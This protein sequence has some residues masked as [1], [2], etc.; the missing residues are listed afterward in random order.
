M[1]AVWNF[2]KAIS[3]FLSSNSQK[4]EKKEKKFF[5]KSDEK[6]FGPYFLWK[7]FLI[8][9]K[10]MHKAILAETLKEH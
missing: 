8:V 1:L 4:K 6:N 10:R 5:F 9:Y 7:F 2:R 3:S